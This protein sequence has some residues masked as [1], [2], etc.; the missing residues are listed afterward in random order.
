MVFCD[1]KNIHSENDIDSKKI[2]IYLFKGIDQ[3]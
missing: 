2:E 1:G 3:D